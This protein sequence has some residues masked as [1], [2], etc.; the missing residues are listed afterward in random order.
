MAS[1]PSG[2]AEWLDLRGAADVACRSARLTAAMAA[3][4][5]NV[6]CLRAMDLGTGTGANFRHLASH[7]PRH[8]EWTLV[9][10]D[11]AVLAAVESRTAA[12]ARALG[13]DLR[14]DRSGFTITAP[15]LACRV[16]LAH[17]DFGDLSHPSLF[18]RTHLVT[19]SA[20]L[21]LASASWIAELARRCGAIGAAA[22]IAITYNGGSPCSPVDPDDDLVRDLFNEHQRTDK[23]LGGIAAGPTSPGLAVDAFAGAGYRVERERSDWHLAHDSA[24][25]QRA[26]IDGW[27]QAA[28]EIAPTMAVRINAWRG[29]RLNA[30]EA[31]DLTI[32]VGHEDL[33][34]LP[35][36]VG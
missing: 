23:G 34:A 12:W 32:E 16:R 15:T 30:V 27:A 20:L 10:R 21:D 13:Y 18:E 25:L 35:A 8:Q 31:G 3:A 24:D 4:F 36:A 26:L 11:V 9:D 17:L 14:S 29:R 33:L 2:L 5:R 7:L 1:N 19:A 28:L 22:L 6:D